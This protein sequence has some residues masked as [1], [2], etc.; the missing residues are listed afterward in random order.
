MRTYS[1][2]TLIGLAIALPVAAVAQ[3]GAVPSP[4]RYQMIVTPGSPSHPFL[5]DTI[6]GCVWQAIE[7]P[8]TKRTGFIEVEVQNLHWGLAS[9]QIIAARIDNNTSLNPDQKRTIKQ[10]LE[11]TR[12]GAFSVLLTPPAGAPGAAGQPGPAKIPPATPPA[13]APAK[14]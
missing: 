11:K 14:R 4:G 9:Q 1:L 10:E 12:C 3:Q 5:L 8:E 2:V 6:T 13:K 7:E